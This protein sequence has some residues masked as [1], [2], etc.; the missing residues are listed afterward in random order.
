MLGQACCKFLASSITGRETQPLER[1]SFDDYVDTCFLDLGTRE[2]I[3][4]VLTCSLVIGQR[5]APEFAPCQSMIYYRDGA[6]SRTKDH[7][8]E[9][10]V[11]QTKGKP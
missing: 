10:G 4:R 2:K 9:K 6:G 5:S 11:C 3:Q 7:N 8:L 1:M